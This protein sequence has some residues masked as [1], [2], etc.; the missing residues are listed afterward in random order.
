VPER[1]RALEPQRARV[2]Q[3]AKAIA[4]RQVRVLPVVESQV[5]VPPVKVEPQVLEP[6]LVQ[7]VSLVKVAPAQVRVEPQVQVWLVG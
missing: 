4:E 7:V 1:I 6:W 3:R 2:L 5:R